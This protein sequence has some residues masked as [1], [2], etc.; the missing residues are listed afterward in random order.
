ME[1]QG[2]GPAVGHEAAATK[3]ESVP[4]QVWIGHACW[5]PERKPPSISD[6]GHQTPWIS[7][8]RLGGGQMTAV[9]MGPLKVVDPAVVGRPDIERKAGIERERVIPP[10]KQRIDHLGRTAKQEQEPGFRQQPGPPLEKQRRPRI[11]PSIDI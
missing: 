3:V 6:G 10:T 7:H 1:L 2:G 11:L 4:K 9:G 8:G 5:L